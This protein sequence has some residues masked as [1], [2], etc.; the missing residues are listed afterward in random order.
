MCWEEVTPGLSSTSP[1]STLLG[2]GGDGLVVV[3]A[4]NRPEALDPALRRPV[5]FERELKVG[6]PGSVARLEILKARCAPPIGRIM[7]RGRWD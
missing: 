5:R 4:T 3:A 2:P 7:E 1:I 6:V